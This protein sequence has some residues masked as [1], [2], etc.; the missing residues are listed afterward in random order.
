M[1]PIPSLKEEKLTFMSIC[2]QGE[3]F[4][5]PKELKQG[6]ALEEVFTTAEIPKEVDKLQE[7]CKGF[8]INKL[9]VLAS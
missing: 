4:V 1:P 3:F 2:N 7:E 5:E 9:E 8:E 6:V